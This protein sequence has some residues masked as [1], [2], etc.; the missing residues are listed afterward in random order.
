[1]F[2]NDCS[3]LG[4]VSAGTNAFDRNVRGNRIII[5]KPCTVRALFASVPIHVKIQAID[6]PMKIAR[7][8]AASTPSGPPC[9]R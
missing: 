6:Q 3:Q 1:M 2:T 8:I 4:S 5:E 7:A 9:G